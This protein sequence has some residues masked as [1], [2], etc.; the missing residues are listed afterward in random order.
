MF[1]QWNA[2]PNGRLNPFNNPS[3]ASAVQSKCSYP[4]TSWV[5]SKYVPV[6]LPGASAKNALVHDP[7][8]LKIITLLSKFLHTLATKS[9]TTLQHMI[10]NCL[11]ASKT[12]LVA[13][14]RLPYCNIFL[15]DCLPYFPRLFWRWHCE[16]S[17]SFTANILV[18]SYEFAAY[19]SQKTEAQLLRLVKSPNLST[20]FLVAMFVGVSSFDTYARTTFFDH[21]S[22]SLISF[23]KFIDAFF[24]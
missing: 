18:I 16:D 22:T 4:C 12:G 1:P 24:T 13:S 20:S 11:Q 6:I 19:F 14:D 8:I 23:P 3:N 7:T 10:R 21:I 17:T 9:M 5:L 2:Q 15:Q